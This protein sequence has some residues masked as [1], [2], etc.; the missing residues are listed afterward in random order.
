M[1]SCV[2]NIEFIS[3]ASGG[4]CDQKLNQKIKFWKDV[5]NTISKKDI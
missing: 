3:L 5:F 1:I 4:G 2:L